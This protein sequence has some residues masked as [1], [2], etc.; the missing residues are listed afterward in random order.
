[1]LEVLTNPSE[2]FENKMKQEADFKPPVMI[3]GIMAIISAISAYIVAST[4]IG[5][6]PSDAAS[7]A[8]I[9]MIIGA[10]FA[11]IVVFIMWAIYSGIF[12]LLSMVFGGQ[13]NFKRVLEFVAYG[14]LP[15]ILGSLITLILTSKAYSSLDFSISDP[16]LLQKA[17]LSNPYIMASSVIGIILTLWSAN[18]WVFAMIHSRNLTVKNALLTVGIPIG[19]YL[20]YTVYNLYQALS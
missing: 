4:I 1:M 15:S 17:I 16:T 13:G 11:I 12:Y 3:I 14:F 5:S 6:L 19:L 8:Q 7:F 20:I 18:I 9:G 10:I 2:F